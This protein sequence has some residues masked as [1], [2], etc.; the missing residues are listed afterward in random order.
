MSRE[1]QQH[2]R[3]Q[4]SSGCVFGPQRARAK[5]DEGLEDSYSLLKSLHK[6]NGPKARCVGVTLGSDDLINIPTCKANLLHSEG[7]SY[8]GA[9]HEGDIGERAGGEE[10]QAQTRHMETHEDYMKAAASEYFACMQT[11]RPC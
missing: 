2:M 5:K 3:R 9:T 10:A 11:L 4:Q 7:C 6:S 1:E 8:D